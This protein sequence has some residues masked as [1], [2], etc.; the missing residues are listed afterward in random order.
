GSASST[1]T[2][3]STGINATATVSS[4][5]NSNT[6]VSTANG[7]GGRAPSRGKGRDSLD[8]NVVSGSG[9]RLAGRRLDGRSCASMG[10][11]DIRTFGVSSNASG[12]DATVSECNK[13]EVNTVVFPTAT[14]PDT[15]RSIHSSLYSTV[16][17][18]PV[19]AARIGELTASVSPP[20]IVNTAAALTTFGRL[21]LCASPADAN[22]TASDTL[23]SRSYSLPQMKTLSSSPPSPSPLDSTEEDVKVGLHC[24][25]GIKRSLNRKCISTEHLEVFGPCPEPSILTDS[26]GKP[27]ISMESSST[28]PMVTTPYSPTSSVDTLDSDRTLPMRYETSAQ[29]LHL[30]SH[31][32]TCRKRCSLL[33]RCLKMAM[34]VGGPVWSECEPLEQQVKQM[35]HL[36]VEA[37]PVVG[38]TLHCCRVEECQVYTASLV[39]QTPYSTD[40]LSSTSP[41][42]VF[43]NSTSI[44]PAV[45]IPSIST[46]T[47]VAVQQN[48]HPPSPVFPA[49]PLSPIQ[50]PPPPPPP[51][52]PPDGVNGSSNVS[53]QSP[54]V[55]SSY[56]PPQP[57][58]S[59][60]VPGVAWMATPHHFSSTFVPPPTHPS[61]TFFDPTTGAPVFACCLPPQPT[62]PLPPPPSQVPQV[63]LQTFLPQPDQALLYSP[64]PPPPPPP[65]TS[66]QQAFTPQ[67]GYAPTQPM[68]ILEHQ[69]QHQQQQFQHLQP[70][71]PLVM[72]AT[73]FYDLL[74]LLEIADFGPL[75]NLLNRLTSAGAEAGFSEKVG[76]KACPEK[77]T[78]FSL[79]ETFSFLCP[80]NRGALGLRHYTFA[81]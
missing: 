80:S 49:R 61:P 27:S 48:P 47:T 5:T 67:M 62:P 71:F 39:P 46:S 7:S 52:P 33:T 37:K 30:P 66:Q 18:S 36:H 23:C 11:R 21:S 64:P 70:Q 29:R 57:C 4:T 77:E 10:C 51:L 54:F 76:G 73:D 14:T 28:I 43:H 79:N 63:P 26:H 81:G 2:S 19:E 40:S 75:E 68:P 3:A 17:S 53:T 60:Y 55:Y 58:C 72:D 8:S 15:P 32:R 56:T 50:L 45:E 44:S 35:T 24:C 41:P 69:N 1:S 74:L 22:T 20:T 34:T 65:L 42:F 13:K 9:K 38:E 59:M 31:L 78:L 12:H 25:L 6:K 16:H